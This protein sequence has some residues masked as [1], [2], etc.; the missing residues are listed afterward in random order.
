MLE[1]HTQI[2]VPHLRGTWSR[3]EEHFIGTQQIQAQKS[4]TRKPNSMEGPHTLYMD[5]VSAPRAAHATHIHMQH[6][7]SLSKCQVLV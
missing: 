6:I 2:D 5:A 4:L 1:F 7:Q 3:T